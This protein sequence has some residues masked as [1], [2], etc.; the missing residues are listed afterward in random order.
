MSV[1]GTEFPED[2]KIVEIS[3]EGYDA[4][5]PIVDGASEIP[6]WAQGQATEVFQE[7]HFP[8]RSVQIYD[9]NNV[10]VCNEGILFDQ[11]G[12]Y[13][14]EMEDFFSMKQII[15]G[16][17]LVQQS[18]FDSM[19]CYYDK[20]VVLCKRPTPF[21]YGHW[22]IDMLPAAFIAL[23]Y[24]PPD[25]AQSVGFVL[26]KTGCTIDGIMGA[27]L[28]RLGVASG[29]ML[30]T[31][32]AP[33]FF[34]R[35]IFVRNLTQHGQYISPLVNE[36]HVE[37]AR[38]VAGSDTTR[39]FVRRTGGY[40]RELRNEM[41]LI[42]MAR[43][44][45]FDVCDPGSLSFLEQISMFKNATHI[46]GAIGSAMT[47]VIYAPISAQVTVLTPRSMPDSFYWHLCQLRLQTFREFRCNEVGPPPLN[48][49]PPWHVD[50]FM[51]RDRFQRA[52]AQFD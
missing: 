51:E 48:D 14:K 43:L 47:N 12:R 11:H 4:M 37:I 3:S 50:F 33:V 22:M 15:A 52:L 32:Q 35:L 23:R 36:C 6:Q 21:V 1:I 16:H 31:T 13:F 44:R 29:R 39:L 7:L 5:P 10:Y 19:V 42:E 34:K 9:L 28:G 18:L 8:A 24:L 38:D 27:S 41:E 26:H 46:I 17:R 2:N 49:G 25:L 45:G 30:W 20:P 40:G